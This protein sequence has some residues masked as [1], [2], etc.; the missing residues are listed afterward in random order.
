MKIFVLSSIYLFLVTSCSMLDTRTETTGEILERSTNQKIFLANY[1]K[2]WRAAHSTLKYTIASENQD[3]G[4]IETDYIKAVDG[5]I[6][7]YQEKPA[8]PGARYKLILNFAK[9][10]TNGKESTRVTIEKK[11]EVFKNVIS[12]AQTIPSDGL[13][14]KI[15]FYRMEREIII[16][17]ALKRAAEKN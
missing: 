10:K 3:F 7:P 17:D 12:E 16:A 11:V 13:E 8:I 14:E 2:V 9:G 15:I 4:V 1:D 5:Y 6:P